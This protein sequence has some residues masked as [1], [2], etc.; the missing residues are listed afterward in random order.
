MADPQMEQGFPIATVAE[1]AAIL[2]WAHY[3]VPWGYGI[4]LDLSVL[5][6]ARP[7]RR[8]LYIY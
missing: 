8:E 7:Q 1:R 6:V 2:P 5:S 3:E 4:Q